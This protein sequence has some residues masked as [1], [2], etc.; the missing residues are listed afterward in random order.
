MAHRCCLLIRGN[1]MNRE[2]HPSF[3]YVLHSNEGKCECPDEKS[4]LA[5][6]SNSIQRR[7]FGNSG[8]AWGQ[9]QQYFELVAYVDGVVVFGDGYCLLVKKKQKRSIGNVLRRREGRSVGHWP[10]MH[11]APCV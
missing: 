5:G 8:L 9:M 2:C 7:M 10:E 4:S 11:Y 3:S 1:L 6:I